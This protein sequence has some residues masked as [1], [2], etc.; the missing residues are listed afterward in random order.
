M[1]F[2]TFILLSAVC[3]TLGGCTVKYGLSGASIPVNAKTYSV[4]YFPNN[5][6]LVNPN[7]SSTFTEALKDKISRQS[8]LQEDR[9]S[10]GEMHFEGEI[11]GY[12]STSKAI[13]GNEQAVTNQLTVT[14]RVRFTNSLEPKNNF[15]KSFQ[16]Y[17]DY[18]S[19]IYLQ[20]AEPQL[21]PQITETLVENIFNA[22]FSNW[23]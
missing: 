20:D 4:S 5:A 19:A 14:V 9:N 18:S 7:L 2:K 10:Q 13:T 23:N 1:N 15:D 3:L 17:Q 11:T 6:I 22:A 16:A 8:R 21:I 12:T